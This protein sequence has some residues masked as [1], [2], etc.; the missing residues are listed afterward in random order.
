MSW[1]RRGWQVFAPEPALDRWLAAVAPHA[2]ACAEEPS[3]TSRWLRHGGTWFA[4]VDVLGNDADGGLAGSG[5]LRCAARAEAERIAGRL[6]LHRGQVSVTYP[7]YPGRDLGESEARH[8]YRRRRDAAHL[9]GLLPVG[10]S[11]RRMIREP[12]GYI[13]GLPLTACPAEKAPL[14]VWE[15]SHELIRAAMREALSG[16][17]PASWADVDVTE[18]YHAARTACF[19]RCA[20]VEISASVGQAILLHRLTLHGVAP[21]RAHSPP[22]DRRAILYFRPVLRGGVRDWLMQA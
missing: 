20:R 21:W 16:H 3:L 4:G 7:G 5:P 11:R 1:L 17:P 14:V 12:H 8:R 13:L 2:V 18:A 19:E 9:D 22:E 6:P 15:G 10:E